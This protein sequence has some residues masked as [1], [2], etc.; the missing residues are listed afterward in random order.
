MPVPDELAQ[1]LVPPELYTEHYFRTCCGDHE[2]W[3]RSSGREVGGIYSAILRRAGLRPGQVVVDLGTGRGELLAVAV[4]QGAERAIGVEYAEA[5]VTLARQTLEVHG[6]TDRAEAILAD[7]RS[8]PLDDGTADLVT[9]LDV[10]EHLSP[11]ELVRTLGEALR[12]LKPG[13]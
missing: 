9:M 8:V 11:A 12:I 4:E 1:P 5:A 13:G 6:V 10:V 3:S 2:T 7:A